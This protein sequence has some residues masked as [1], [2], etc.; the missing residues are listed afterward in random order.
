MEKYVIYLPFSPVGIRDIPPNKEK[1]FHVTSTRHAGEAED[2][3]EAV[4]SG[5]GLLEL[6]ATKVH[7]CHGGRGL[8][9]DYKYYCSAEMMYEC[10]RVCL[11]KVRHIRQFLVRKHKFLL[12]NSAKVKLFAVAYC[13][14]CAISS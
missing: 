7:Y 11:A 4:G 13:V 5:P 9:R 1:I 3:V 6:L 2:G 14:Q 8:C 12:N 10:E